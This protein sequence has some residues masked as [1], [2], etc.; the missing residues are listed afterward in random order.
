MCA[1]L[2]LVACGEKPSDARWLMWY[3]KPAEVFIETLVMGN[4]QQGAI[5]YGGVERERIDLNDMTLWSGEPVDVNVDTLAAKEG[6]QAVR[7]ALA[8]EDYAEAN[9]LQKRL[10][11]SFSEF[12]LPMGSLLIDF[13]GENEV[14]NY[15]R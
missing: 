8:K 12:Y 7:D 10:Q 14:S 4:G 15:S 13:E 5:I 6:L 11:G 1:I 9:R 2:S 3:D